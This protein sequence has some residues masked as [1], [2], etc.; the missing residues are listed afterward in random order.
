MPLPN[1]THSPNIVAQASHMMNSLGIISHIMLV[2]CIMLGLGLFTGAMFQLRRFA[3]SRTYMSQQMTLWGPMTMMLAAILLLLLPFTITT[4]LRAF[5]GAGQ[6]LP[7]AYQP[8]SEHDFDVY[9]PVVLAFVRLIGVGAIIRACTIFSR[10]G[11]S[12]GQPGLI[13][14]ALLHLFGGILCVHV[15]GTMYLIKHIFGINT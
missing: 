14:K 8:T 3:E 4:S 15:L 13:G 12:S 11:R 5:F 6:T 7:I 10:A 1:D 9:V 2:I